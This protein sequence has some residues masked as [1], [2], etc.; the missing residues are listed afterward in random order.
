[1]IR[2]GTIPLLLSIF[3]IG[4][5]FL[6][7]APQ[8]VQTRCREQQCMHKSVL[9]AQRDKSRSG[10]KRERLNR[11]A[12]LEESRVETDKSFVGLAAGGFVG[13]LVLLLVVA[14]ASGVMDPI[15]NTGY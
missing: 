12:E 11:L 15:M 7:P 4:N 9:M 5:A 8:S 2:T 3:C 14:F 6:V 13:L 10:T 1:M